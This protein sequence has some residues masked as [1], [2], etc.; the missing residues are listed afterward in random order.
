MTADTTETAPVR[1]DS[2]AEGT[3]FRFANP[4]P[5]AGDRD[6]GT[7]AVQIFDGVVMGEFANYR[8]DGTP[9]PVADQPYDGGICPADFAVVPV[10]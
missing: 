9:T 6:P 10:S 8:A 5:A 3:R 2:L 7:E 4:N 1:I